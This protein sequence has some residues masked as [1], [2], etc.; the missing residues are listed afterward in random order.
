MK[1][2]IK[3]HRRVKE[4]WLYQEKRTFSRFEA[5]VD[6][7]LEANHKDN[8]FPLGNEIVEC[9]RGQLITSVRQL[10]DRWRWSNTKVTNFLKLLQN[11]NMITYFSDT[12][13]TVITIVNYELYQSEDDTITTNERHDNDARTTREHTNKN[14]KNVKNDKN[15]LAKGAPAKNSDKVPSTVRTQLKFWTKSADCYTTLTGRWATPKDEVAIAD[16][17]HMTLDYELVKKIMTDVYRRYE[18]KV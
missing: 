12:K 10:C 6:L 4:N 9:K 14:D 1:G 5:W 7:L 18:P 17:S 8:K 3:L 15:I 2:W 11:D 13:K 16:V